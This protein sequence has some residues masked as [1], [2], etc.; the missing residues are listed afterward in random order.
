M[1]KLGRDK[2]REIRKYRGKTSSEIAAITG[3]GINTVCRYMRDKRVEK[4]WSGW[5]LERLCK[6]RSEGIKY[7]EIGKRLRRTENSVKIKMH[8]YRKAIAND[9]QKRVV[10][11]YLSEAFRMQPNPTLALRAVRKARIFEMG[12]DLK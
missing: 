3:I 9:P 6:W 4:N 12:V 7:A 11:H 10:L 5:E 2:I 1:K 8:K